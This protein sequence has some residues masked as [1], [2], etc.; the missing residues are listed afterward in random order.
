MTGK[1]PPEASDMQDLAKRYLELWNK[2]MSGMG[3][4]PAL[5]EA[6][7][8]ALTNSF[9]AMSQGMAVFAQGVMKPGEAHAPQ[10]PRPRPQAADAAS[11]GPDVL[12]AEFVGRLAA[13]EER[14]AVLERAVLKPG[15]GTR[16]RKP[17]GV[18]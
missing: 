14:L 1:P 4:D 5:A 9:Q 2:Q 8:E 6:V 16:K 3:G 7:A 15:P 12:P 11:G 18:A 13:L 17:R 10:S